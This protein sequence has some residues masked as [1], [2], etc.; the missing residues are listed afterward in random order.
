MY[1]YIYMHLY[2]HIYKLEKKNMYMV[3]IDEKILMRRRD[4]VVE[5]PNGIDA[6]KKK[7]RIRVM[8]R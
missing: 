7:N 3:C 2:I 5:T 6:R 4:N 8:S 1:I